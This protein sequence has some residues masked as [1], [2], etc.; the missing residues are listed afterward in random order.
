MY[1]ISFAGILVIISPGSTIQ[2]ITGLVLALCF[3]KLY[4]NYEPY[5][6]DII[7]SL[8]SLTQ[9][10]IYTVYFIALLI[11]SGDL[12]SSTFRIL[13]QVVLILAI[14]A[15]II[16]DIILFI[17]DEISFRFGTQSSIFYGG[18][19][20]GNKKSEYDMNSYNSSKN[21]DDVNNNTQHVITMSPMTSN[22]EDGR[23]S[24]AELVSSGASGG[25]GI[26]DEDGR[27][28]RDRAISHTE[29]VGLPSS[30]KMFA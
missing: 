4:S 16:F 25:G 1:C 19:N 28:F 9:W 12:D 8:K 27:C 14:F 5:V 3:I 11:H 17:V 20:S 23:S 30:K 29:M 18:T 13:L 26:E 2:I 22:G 10:Q 24:Q 15:N 7:S 21:N 6:D